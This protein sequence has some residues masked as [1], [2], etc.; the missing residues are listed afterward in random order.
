MGSGDGSGYFRGLRAH[1]RNHRRIQPQPTRADH[2]PD[3]QVAEDAHDRGRDQPPDTAT[4]R[5]DRH[6]CRGQDN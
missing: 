2:E 4:D 3:R 1:G 5:Q 6:G